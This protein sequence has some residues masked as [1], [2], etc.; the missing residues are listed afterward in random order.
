MNVKLKLILASNAIQ[1]FAATLVV[2]VF[3]VLTR[4][5]GGGAE[6]AGVLFGISFFVTSLGNVVLM[7]V[8]DG[9]SRDT[10]LY[11]LGLVVKI[12]AWLLLAY[13]QSIAS[14][15]IA[16]IILG[17]ATAAGA[18]AFSALVSSHLDKRKHISDWAEW[19]FMSNIATALSSVLSGFIVVRYGFTTLFIVM[20]MVT[21]A[22]LML[23]LA[24]AGQAHSD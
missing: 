23:S 9:R 15:V 21:F 20:A 3:A 8:K 12:L 17:I 4:H 14:M 16:Q 7:R 2:P 5:V 6:L 10:L 24:I 19:N 22:A 18:P 13:N 11:K 1:V